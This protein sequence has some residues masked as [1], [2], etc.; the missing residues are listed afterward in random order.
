M[1]VSEVLEGSSSA[2]QCKAEQ[3]SAVQCSAV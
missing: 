1:K 3:S 2:V